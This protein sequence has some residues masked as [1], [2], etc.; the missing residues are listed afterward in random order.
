MSKFDELC[1]AYVIDRLKYLKYQEDCW[2]FGAILVK[3]L[4]D[5]LQC[6]EDN[7][8]VYPAKGEIEPNAK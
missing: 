4:R 3:G 6:P 8:K 1:Q 2:R 5:Y 7:I